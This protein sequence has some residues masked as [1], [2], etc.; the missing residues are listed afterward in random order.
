MKPIHVLLIEH[1]REESRRIGDMLDASPVV[2]FQVE[3]V[4]RLE[5]HQPEPVERLRPLPG[6]TDNDEIRPPARC[7]IH[8]A[9]YAVRSSPFAACAQ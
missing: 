5:K 4:D 6:S 7:A 3:Q 9:R 1:Q 2:A 8:W